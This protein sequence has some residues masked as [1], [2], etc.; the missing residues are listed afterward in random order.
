ME[1]WSKYEEKETTKLY[2]DCAECRFRRV[3]YD[4][5]LQCNTKAQSFWKKEGY[6]DHEGFLNLKELHPDSGTQHGVFM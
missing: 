5:L 3:E 2:C 6:W 1:S 4:I